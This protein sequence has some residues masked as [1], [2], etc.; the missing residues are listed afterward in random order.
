MNF[1]C[2]TGHG[3]EVSLSLLDSTDSVLEFFTVEI[4][5]LFDIFFKGYIAKVELVPLVDEACLVSTLSSKEVQCKH[6]LY[7][8][9]YELK[10]S[11][12]TRILTRLAEMT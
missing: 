10:G 4:R 12:I 2:Y 1:L 3:S 9:R 8:R 6:A 11:R 7:E 5:S